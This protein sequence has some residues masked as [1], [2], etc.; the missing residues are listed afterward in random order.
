[1]SSAPPP[2]HAPATS[3]TLFCP[4]NRRKRQLRQEISFCPRDLFCTFVIRMRKLKAITALFFLFLFLFPQVEKGIH[5]L[6]HADDTH[7]TDVSEA[8]FHELSHLC[9]LCDYVFASPD[10]LYFESAISDEPVSAVKGYF[11][12]S[13]VFFSA[14]RYNLSLRAPPVC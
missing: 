6:E 8:H 5:D 13:E 9:S 1:M 4:T 7:C 3:I 2:I 12:S 11:I 10:H 14:P